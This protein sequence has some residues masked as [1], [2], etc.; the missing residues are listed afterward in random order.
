MYRK[1]N[2]MIATRQ[3]D[4]RANLKKY[5]DYAFNGEPVIVSRKENKN[6]VVISE[7]EY[8][9]LLKAKRNAEYLAKL[10]KSREE[11][12]QGKTISFSMDEL[13]AMESNDWKP[14][15]KIMDFMGK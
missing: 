2:N 3:M 11:L 15:K 12:E 13:K 7:K 14:T 6:V 5:F 10:D 9:D 8:N 4:I 1:G